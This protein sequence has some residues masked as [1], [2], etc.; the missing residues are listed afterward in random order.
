M[1]EI[2]VVFGKRRDPG[3]ILG[4]TIPQAFFLV[5]ALAFGVFF[6]RSVSAGD[7][8]RWALLVAGLLIAP[9]GFIRINGRGIAD[10]GP[11]LVADWALRV[12]GQREYRGGPHRRTALDSATTPRTQPRLP[13]RSAPW[14]S[15]GSRSGR[16]AA[17]S[18]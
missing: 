16:T 6:F 9:V 11:A 8:P 1:S 15:W 18:G 4:R 13:G 3:I 2:R 10:V 5:V 12:A 14:R 7:G 17:R